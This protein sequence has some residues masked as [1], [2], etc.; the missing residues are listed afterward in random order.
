MSLSEFALKTKES[1]DE[2][3]ALA[4]EYQTKFDSSLTN[5]NKEI[6]DLRQIMR[7]CS[8]NFASPDNSAQS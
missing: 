4:L 5:I 2:V 6:S 1:R 7:K 8:Q 3:T